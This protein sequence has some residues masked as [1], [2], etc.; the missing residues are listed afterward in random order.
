MRMKTCLFMVKLRVNRL[1]AAEL[2]N[3]LAAG[4]RAAQPTGCQPHDYLPVR[5]AF[6]ALRP[7]RT[8]AMV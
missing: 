6:K 7:K 8:L 4:R 3:L 5:R 1:R 2:L